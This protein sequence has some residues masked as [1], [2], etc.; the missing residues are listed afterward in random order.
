MKQFLRYLFVVAAML[1]VVVGDVWGQKP[2]YN[3]GTWYSL[4]DTGEN[5]NVN[6]LSPDFAEKSV[7][8][9]AESMT[10]EYKKF[11]LLSTNGKVEV[12]NKV[13]GTDWSSSKGSVSYSDRKNWNTSP[14]ISLDANI[15]HIRYKMASGTGVYVRNHFVKLKKHILLYDG[16]YGKASEDVTFDDIIVGQVSGEK[17][18]NLRSFLT[19]KNGIT[20]TSSNPSVFRVM[21][22]NNTS[23]YTFNV[24]AN[25]CAAS[26]G[27][28]DAG[29]SNLGDIS[30]YSV[31]IYFCPTETKMY[32]ET[33]TIS[34]GTST[35]TINVSGKGLN[36][37]TATFNW[38][39]QDS[40]Y[41]GDEKSLLDEVYSLVDKD[42][43]NIKNQFHS[44]IQFSS[45]DRNVVAI[46]NGKL[47]AKNVGEAKITAYFPGTNEWF[48]FTA[49]IDLTIKKRP[50]NFS[51]KTLS[52][53][54]TGDEFAISSLFNTTTNNPEV[55]LEYISGDESIL[56]VEDGKLIAVCVGTTTFTVRQQENYKWLGH[57]QTLTI[58]V[59][60]YNSNFN[61][62]QPQYT[63]KIGEVITEAQLYTHSN[64]E[65][66]PLVVS[67]N[68][69]VVS[70]NTS[71]R[72]LEAKTAGQAIITISQ[73]EDCKWTHY[74]A[75]CT[76]T[77]QKHTPIFTWNDPVYHNQ[78]L[79]EDYFSTNNKDS[80]L[81]IASASSDVD[82]AQLYFSKT[83]PTD[84]HTLDL[85]TYN[86]EAS[87]KVTVSQ[88]ENWYWYAKSEEHTITPIDPNNHV[89]FVIDS[90]ERRN[91]FD[92]NWVADE[93]TWDNGIQL[94][95]WTDGGSWADKYVDIEFRGVPD[96]LTFNTS[97]KNAGIFP[98]S[99]IYWYVKESEDGVN[100][101]GE[102]WNEEDTK[103]ITITDSIQLQPKTRFIR[104]CYSGNFGG[105][106][107]NITVTER[108]E[109][110]AVDNSD[111]DVDSLNFEANQVF[112]D[113]TLSFN[114]KY[115]N[116]GYK[117]KVESND[118]R[119]TVNPTSI[120]T[121]GGCKYGKENISV[122][123]SSTIP[124]ETTGNSYI[125]ISDELAELNGH[126][127][128]VYLRASSYKP[129]QT[130]EWRTDFKAV[131]KPIIRVKN[132]QITDAAT[133][134][135]GMPV[136]Y[137]SSNK[138]VIDVSDD[139]RILIPVAAGEATITA[140]QVGNE[141]WLPVSD[142]KTFIVTDKT[143]QYIGW[144]DD[145]TGL[146][147]GDADMTLTAKVY[148]RDEETQ[149]YIYSEERTNLLQYS[150]GDV[151]VV[152]VSGN[153][154]SI[155]GVG[156]TTATVTAPSDEDYA[157]ATLTV[158][159]RVRTASAGCEDV[160]LLNHPNEVGFFA[161]N[162]N[163]I[164]Q[165]P[166]GID[167]E[168]G[169]PGSLSFQ[170][171]GASWDLGIQYYGG[172]IK[173]QYVT[174]DNS[175]WTDAIEVTPI[176]DQA[177]FE[178][179]IY[180]PRNATQI[181]FVRPSGAVGYHYVSNIQVHPAQYLEAPVEID[182]GEIHVGSN[183]SKTFEVNYSNIK[184]V[185]TLTTSS[186]N[187]SVLPTSFGEC[188]RYDQETIT[189]TWIPSQ[190]NETAQETVT[191]TDNTSG[192]QCVV[193]LKANV[194][195][196][197]QNLSWPDRPTTISNC[198]DVGFPEQTT[199]HIDIIWEV[200]SGKD[201][202][203]FVDGRLELYK[204]GTITVKGYNIGN[205]NYDSFE[206]RYTLAINVNPTF[207][208]TNDA[209]WNNADNW[210]IC[211]LPYESDIVTIAAPVELVT[212]E[213]VKGIKLSVDGN[214]HIASNAGL[215]IGSHG[216]EL[217]AD[218]L[219]TIDNTPAGAGFLRVDPKA[220]Y[221]PTKRVKINYTT[222]AYDSGIPR[223]EVWQYMG[224]PGDSMRMDDV[225]KTMIYHWNEVKGWLKQSSADLLPFVG[226]AFTQEKAEE[227]TF[228]LSAIPIIP[229]EEQEIPLTV[230]ASGM[231]GSN[232]FVNSFLAP[233]DLTKFEDE[234]FE[235]NVEKTFYLFNSGSW[236]QWQQEGGKEHM[237]YGVSPG[238]YYALSPQGADLMDPQYDQT[239]IPPM[240]GVYVI[241]REKAAIHLDYA[242]HVYDAQTSNVAMRAPQHQ[243]E[244]FKRVRFHVSGDNSGADRMYLIQHRQATD[245]YDNGYDARNLAVSG[246]VGIYTNESMG[247]MEISV[248][249]KIDSTY[250]GFRAG[251]DVEYLLR[252]TSVVGDELYLLDLEE[253]VLISLENT[254]E[255]IF[256]A[257]PNSV[258]DKRF[259]LI[260]RKNDVTTDKENVDLVDVYV[261]HKTV[262]IN[263]A[264]ANSNMVVY[265]I[266]GLALASYTVDYAPCSIDLS[267]LPE[268]VYLLRIHDKTYKF[269]CK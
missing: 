88:E 268:G 80:K 153:V 221:I 115:A 173:A 51:V 193:I 79:I 161:Y 97:V 25:A 234:D 77:V 191:F 154:L 120:N 171:R 135:S 61:L 75:T 38:L 119:F 68:P 101:S 33:I 263:Q 197:T 12:Y 210:N 229:T 208:G 73:P 54:Y 190:V 149:A 152:T 174:D 62:L 201:V 111:E 116:A 85:T 172:K 143:V 27:S 37:Y 187:V 43:N 36:K 181:R 164:V 22:Q 56:K 114:L 83:S 145:L 264:P 95:D 239:T 269:V 117:V 35:A 182:F 78:E 192:M 64:T 246:Q 175:T 227:A 55:A 45:S 204:S 94:G 144:G 138:E 118:S 96:K 198:A 244:D 60:K 168:K 147:L 15:S 159:V 72:Q 48:G 241:A 52:S 53:C 266:G 255:Y 14:T 160:L 141:T 59:N 211:R 245:G 107:H 86:K 69:S 63:R 180:L 136:T 71:T 139:G 26:G 216:L 99:D 6:S 87:T 186:A 178:S 98:A 104:L 228:T 28:G 170:H 206:V 18:V 81:S 233:I 3:N 9:P 220:T 163:E 5:S 102:I 254:D 41:V 126:R 196:G 142:T 24:G 177:T 124:Y 265:T 16:G 31:K 17:I 129:E 74:N 113:K 8:A 11:S 89:P 92:V 223:D 32:N 199:A 167:K 200:T 249:N 151:N 219:I 47:V 30:K 179:E 237:N 67:N 169:V 1:M 50:T 166:F 207:L 109:F 157:E 235:G 49:E 57:S 90:E 252:I 257:T 238:Q 231:G 205:D 256:R 236:N 39:L 243:D 232:L 82:V 188:G 108:E 134:K 137:T 214:I 212:C 176:E 4:Y 262:Y 253:N 165:G 44:S 156:Q 194:V 140:T 21:D 133:A 105:V 7:F 42:G 128:T 247:Q 131:E 100:W 213:E 218:E 103:N 250:I 58:T 93:Y 225:D 202:A 2:V 203:D 34:D 240:Q 184:D 224:A 146:V 148:L 23:T 66:L 70:F 209:D 259:L 127:D 158:P 91:V 226:Y 122:T 123:Y 130:L 258:N 29:G 248:S 185:V 19:D 260:D 121:I 84:L 10:F 222:H 195:K 189:V 230:T 267:A 112:T 76:V 132:G 251:V 162:T 65:I 242:K 46:E 215:T 183:E 125:V 155:K 20:I 261:S 106:F 217:A 40:Y 110:H 150:V 13:N